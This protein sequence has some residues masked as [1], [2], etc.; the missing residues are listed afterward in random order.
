VANANICVGGTLLDGRA[1]GDQTTH[2]GAACSSRNCSRERPGDPYTCRPLARA[3]EPCAGTEASSEC[4]P[5]ASCKEN[6]CK[7]RRV[8]GCKDNDECATG[9]CDFGI[10]VS[11]GACYFAWSDKV[12]N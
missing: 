10:C 3:F 9:H 5:G 6:V 1:C 7:P 12:D 8:I 11:T 2:S 4:E